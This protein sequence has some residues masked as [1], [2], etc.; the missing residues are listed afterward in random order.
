MERNIFLKL[1]KE[2]SLLPYGLNYIRENVPEELTVT[3]KGSRYYPYTFYF[4]FKSG[5]ATDMAVLH[6]LKANSHLCVP[7]SEVKGAEE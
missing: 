6:D 3:Y 4:L 5:I 1:C 2:I 7:L